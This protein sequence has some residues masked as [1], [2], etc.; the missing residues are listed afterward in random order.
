MGSKQAIR[1]LLSPRD[2]TKAGTP[3]DDKDGFRMPNTWP[4]YSNHVAAGAGGG[5]GLG[6]WWLKIFGSSRYPASLQLCVWTSLGW[7]TGLCPFLLPTLAPDSHRLWTCRTWLCPNLVITGTI[8]FWLPCYLL[9]REALGH[10]CNRGCDKL[11]CVL[12]QDMDMISESSGYS[13]GDPVSLLV[14][15]RPLP[16]ERRKGKMMTQLF[17][18]RDENNRN[19]NPLNFRYSEKKLMIQK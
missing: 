5:G 6:S 18:V 2:E 11:G 13:L 16:R 12:N 15:R 7:P 4:K 17:L 1:C 14:P 3:W 19:K 9:L 10:L 8:N